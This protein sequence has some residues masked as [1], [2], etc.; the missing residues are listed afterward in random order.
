MS[1]TTALACCPPALAACLLSLDPARL[2]LRRWLSR[3]PI[4]R[5]WVHGTRAKLLLPAPA[6]GRTRT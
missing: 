2:L 1:S 5:R 4:S 6:H 3:L